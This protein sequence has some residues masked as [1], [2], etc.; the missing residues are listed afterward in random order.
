MTLQRRELDPA[1]R[2]AM[3]GIIYRESACLANL[4]DQALWASRLDSGAVATKVETID[5]ALLAREVVT[6][7]QAH[8]PEGL[9]VQLSGAEGPRSV[10]ADAEKLEHV[11]V[12]LVDN[13][14][15]I[16][17]GGSIEAPPAEPR[18]SPRHGA[19][20]GA[21]NSRRRE[22]SSSDKFRRP[23]PEPDAR[24]RRHWARELHLPG[25]RPADGRA[26]LGRVGA[27]T[28]LGVLVRAACRV[29]SGKVARAGIEPATPRFSA[30]V[31]YQLSYLA[32]G[33]QSNSTNS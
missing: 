9:S 23:R 13:A 27:R 1:G 8:L 28:R 29:A 11:L 16:P 6:G 4:V 2:E 25:A 12:N 20:P 17:D 24:G 26:H 5:A 31:L 14:V 33:L 32:R 21:R 15:S 7:A 30:G 19:R 10:R 22:Q 3:L 18:A